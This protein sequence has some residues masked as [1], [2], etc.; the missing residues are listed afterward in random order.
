MKK[1]ISLLLVLALVF[2]FV[3]CNNATSNADNNN[4]NNDNAN[5]S[6]GDDGD[7]ANEPKEKYVINLGITGYPTNTNPFT[8]TMQA[9]HNA[10]RMYETLL[11][12]D[13]QSLEYI[14]KLAEDWTVSEDGKVWEFKLREGVQWQDGESFDA[15]DVVFSFGVIL[16]NIDDENAT[17]ARKADVKMIE[18]I[19]KTGDYEVTFTTKTPVANFYDTP[20]STIKI[21]PEHI[22][23]KMTVA[24]ILDFTNPT[25][26]GTGAW[27]LYGEFNPQNTDLEYERFDDYW[28]EKPYIDGLLYIL[29][30]NSDTMFQAFKAGTLDMFSPS[31]TQATALENEPDVVVIKNM[32]PKLTELG[33]NSYD[34]PSSKG[35]PILLN[36]NVRRAIDYALDKQMLVDN[37]LK[38][39]GYVGTTLV[40]KSAGK[41]HLDIPHDYNPDLAM[42]MLE[43]EGFTDF[44]TVDIS[45]RKVKVRVNDKGEELVFRL[46]LLTEGYA[47]HYRDSM[48]FIVKWLEE[49]GIGL[50]VEPMDGATLGSTMKLDSDSFSDFDMYIWGWTPGYDP[51]FIL[52]VLH[53]DQI[54][55]RQEVMY[56]NP[57]YD[58]LV[59][60]QITQVDMD[61]RMETVHA[62][63]QIIYD[64]APYIPLYYQGGYEAYR[65]DKFE[66]FVQFAGDGT[67][68]NDETY[69]NLRPID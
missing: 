5:I 48:P 37:V 18:K 33:L 60:L 42:S 32:Q 58:R 31:G 39:V 22:W 9:D 61:E 56:S 62:A 26:I 15:D 57:E 51:G 20:L 23:G 41:W 40:P 17:F 11:T 68:F 2:S 36:P 46:A 64:D 7:V 8:Q 6:T 43:E 69:I 50:I 27:K 3:G 65:D 34:D 66:G 28:G 53:T 63:Q 38:G 29:F 44:K 19:E 4:G 52:T 13:A 16:D 54:G 21:L 47:W 1:L 14:G 30:E 24:E 45:G 12:Q 10:L 67:I 49:V 59:D 35:N 55:G 25:P